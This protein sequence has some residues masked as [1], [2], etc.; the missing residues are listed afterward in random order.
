MIEGF[1]WPAAAADAE[2]AAAEEVRR[3][4]KTPLRSSALDPGSCF[5]PWLLFTSIFGAD[6]SFDECAIAVL[7]DLEKMT[8]R[9]CDLA[10]LMFREMLCKAR[11][12]E[13]EESP[14]ACR[15]TSAFR[16]LLS[17]LLARWREFAS[18]KTGFHEGNGRNLRQSA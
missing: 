14:H 15:A 8:D 11:L 7:E 18:M 10:G 12:C 9:R 2:A 16:P 17:E 13:Y 5:D 3:L 6:A 1:Y 4:L